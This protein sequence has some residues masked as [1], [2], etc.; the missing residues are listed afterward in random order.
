[1][2][3]KLIYVTIFGQLKLVVGDWILENHLSS[4]G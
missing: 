2:Q 1:L 3:K 4:N